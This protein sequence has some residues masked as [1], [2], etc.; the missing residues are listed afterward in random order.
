MKQQGIVIKT[1]DNG[2]AQVS[3]KRERACDVCKIKDSCKKTIISVA[4]NAIDAKN[5]DVVTIETPSSLIILYSALV[6]ILPIFIALISYFIGT[7]IFKNDIYPYL[8]SLI[9]FILTFIILN[10]T[11]NKKASKKTVVKIVGIVEA[12]KFKDNADDSS[13]A[14]ESEE[15]DQ[16]K[17]EEI[18]EEK[19]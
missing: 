7:S 18:E 9:C 11:I 5:G 16:V 15:L 8:F 6:F 4:E 19:N 2:T 13:V 12:G 10:I 17:L 14:A 1:E 3:V